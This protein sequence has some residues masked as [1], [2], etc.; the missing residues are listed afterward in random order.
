MSQQEVD[1]LL[2][3]ERIESKRLKQ[4]EAAKILDISPR[5][6]RR[7]QKRYCRKGAC[8]LISKQRGQ[9]SNNRLSSELKARVVELIK[10]TYHDFGPTFAH[11]KLTEIHNLK[12][13][14][15]SVRKIMIGA[16]IWQGKNRKVAEVH[17][18]RTRRSRR[19]ELIQIDGSP[20]DW[21]EGRR[22][23][24]CLNVFIDDAT[25]ELMTLHFTEEECTDGYFAAVEKYL[26]KHGRPLCLYS[27]RH[28]IFRVNTPEAKSGDG[29]TQFGRAMRE[30]GIGTICANSPEAKGRVE[31]VN[32]TL[33]DRLIKEMRLRGISD[34][35]SANAFL[36]EFID[37]FNS[38]FA[39]APANSE[40]VHIQSV[41]SKEVIDLILSKQYDR[42]ISKNLEVS[43][44]NIIYQIQTDT[45]SYN[46]RRASVRVCDRH[47][48]I[49]LLYKGKPLTY[50]TFD[51]KNR[52]AKV[53]SSKQINS[54]LT[55]RA[56]KPSPDH[57]WRT[58]Y[59]VRIISESHATRV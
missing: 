22:S 40:D 6:V 26:D 9:P 20:H 34:I 23:K 35:A 25:S 28:G 3:I 39:V 45:P 59:Q 57:P 33:Q 17:Q 47:G 10:A 42:K 11:E 24:C 58:G 15:E 14:V 16:E 36:P 55:R 52:P 56:C 37:D 12:L 38:R 1:R 5:Q 54:T 21:F 18:T 51:K 41:P 46:M 8:G 2:I 7:L 48:T 32:R 29:D 50:K 13:S 31:R 43:Y 27:D 49:T 30:L 19:G 4:L 44:N 53:I